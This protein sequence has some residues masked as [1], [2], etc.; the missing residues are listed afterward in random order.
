M[1]ASFTGYNF[2]QLIVSLVIFVGILV[3]TYFVTKWIAGYQKSQ[4][5]NRN[6]EVIETQKV[7]NNKYLQ[8]VRVGRDDYYV[9]A[10]GKDEVNF[11]GKLDKSQII[12]ETASEYKGGFQDVFMAFRDKYRK[13]NNLDKDQKKDED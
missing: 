1:F 3:L 4:T 6:F 11:L 9:I 12:F 7:S 5:V 2:F 13:D 10:I 8:I